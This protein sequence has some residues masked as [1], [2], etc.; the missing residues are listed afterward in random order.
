M[1]EVICIKDYT[2]LSFPNNYLVK[3]GEKLHCL[4]SLSGVAPL[5]RLDPKLHTSGY[6]HLPYCHFIAF[7]K[8]RVKAHF[9]LVAS[10]NQR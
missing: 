9:K 7:D 5:F 2:A 3:K 6:A 1:K 10:K 8:A 4:G